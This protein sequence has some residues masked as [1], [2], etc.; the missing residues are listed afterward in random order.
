MILCGVALL[1]LS[2]PISWIYGTGSLMDYLFTYFGM[3]LIALHFI[4]RRALS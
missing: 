1:L 2:E 4:V 3:F